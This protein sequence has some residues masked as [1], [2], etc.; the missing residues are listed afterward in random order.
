MQRFPY[1]TVAAKMPLRPIPWMIC[2]GYPDH[3]EEL[4]VEISGYAVMGFSAGGHLAASFGT[5]NLG[6]AYYG[7]P[8]PATMIL[9]YPVITMGAKTH[10]GS[11]QFLLDDLADDP[12]AQK[13][14][15]IEQQVSDRYPATYVWQFDADDIVPI[16]NSRMLMDAL[17]KNNIP[18]KYET[19]PG[20]LHG[21]G[22]GTGTPA[23]G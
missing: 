22:L 9:C 11:R 10:D 2:T 3:A 19:F 12:T 20:T 1:N 7:L 8:V 16:D 14:Y 18:N 23:E 6:W 4:N 21:A 15:S 17:R 13:K 5:E